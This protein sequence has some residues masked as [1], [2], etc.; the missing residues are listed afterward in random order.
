ML[1]HEIKDFL[2]SSFSSNI[3][4]SLTILKIFMESFLLSLVFTIY[5]QDSSIIINLHVL[6]ET[7]EYVKLVRIVNVL[8]FFMRIKFHKDRKAAI[9]ARTFLSSEN[10]ACFLSGS[11]T[12]EVRRG[13]DKSYLY[14]PR[15][16]LTPA[17]N[18]V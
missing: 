15:R 14:Y 13:E 3:F 7:K 6:A 5:P 4:F 1:S 12:N 11:S 9:F 17:S 16:W 2:L 8:A 10:A 18:K